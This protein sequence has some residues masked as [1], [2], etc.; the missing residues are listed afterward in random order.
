MPEPLAA[1]LC[2]AY[3]TVSFRATENATL[4]CV[5]P[6]LHD[7]LHRDRRGVHWT[8][9]EPTEPETGR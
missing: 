4:Q 5:R 7:G 3:F 9:T 8:I 1:A 2:I 6:D